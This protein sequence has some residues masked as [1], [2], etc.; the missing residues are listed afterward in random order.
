[1][2]LSFLRD[3]E[4]LQICVGR[5]EVI[6]HFEPNIRLTVLSDFGVMAPGESPMVYQD[7]LSG[8]AALFPLLNDKVDRVAVSDGGKRLALTF[9][10]GTRLELMDT[11]DQYESFWIENG[12][13]KIIV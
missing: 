5:N 12:A 1:M 3:I 7:P 2:D 9:R 6:L 13:R 4:L 10:S 11:S 8:A